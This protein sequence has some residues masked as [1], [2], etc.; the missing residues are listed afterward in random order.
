MF[1]NLDLGTEFLFYASRS[2]GPGG[3]NVNKVS[4]KVELRFHVASSG[5]LSGDQKNLVSNRLANRINAAGFLLVVS[6]S[7]RSQLAN[8]QRCVERFYELLRQATLVSKPRKA[9]KPTYS[10]VLKRISAK[11][12]KSGI[13]KMRK[14]P[15]GC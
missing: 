2:C 8:K 10:S 12:N 4:T 6:Q 1:N 13:K 5:L 3:Q 11:K 7:E 15:D 9:T 14:R